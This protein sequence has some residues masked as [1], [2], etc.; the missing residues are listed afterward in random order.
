V[1]ACLGRPSMALCV[2]LVDLRHEPTPDDATLRS[3]LDGQGL[4]CVVAGTKADKLGRGELTRRRAQLEAGLGHGALEVV[5]TS[6]E[7]GTGLPELWRAIR[8]ATHPAQRGA[9]IGR[10]V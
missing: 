2:V 4:A 1:T 8:R 10:E 9:A 3:W 7:D 5:L 6:A